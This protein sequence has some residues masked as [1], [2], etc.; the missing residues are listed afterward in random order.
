VVLIEGEPGIGKSALVRA[1]LADCASLGCQVFW[2]TGS[3]LDQ[4]LPLQ[5]LL[6]GL[7]VRE[8]SPDRRRAT[9][10][11]FLRGEISIDRGMDGSAMLG[12]QL[13]ALIAEEC[14]ARPT[15]LVIDDLQWADNVTIR[16]LARLAGSARELPLLL[17]GMIRPV[18]QRDDLL[19]LRRTAS[20]AVRLGL[21]GLAEAE[22]AELIG[23]LAGGVPDGQLLRLAADAAGN[24]LYITELVE[25]LART[26]RIIVTGGAAVLTAGPAPRSLSAAIADRLGFISGPA[27]EVLQS[28]SLLGPEFPVIDLASLLGRDV[29]DLAAIL[30][31]ACVAGVLAESGRQ[32][33]F[34]HPLI[35]AALYEDLPAPVRTA[36][37]R[38]AGRALAAAGAPPHRVARQLLWAAGEPDGPPEPMDEWILTWLAG[39]AE[40][41]VTQAPQVAA[42]LLAQAV[43]SMPTTA[44]LRG[45]LSGQL[46][47]ALYRTGNKDEAEAVASRELRRAVDPDLLVSLHW[48]LAQCR[49][50]AGLHAE[51]LAAL[52]HALE[53]PGLT[54]RHRGRLLVLA[55]RTYLS[56]GE[57][58][59]AGQVATTALAVAEEACDT[60]AMGWAL[61]TMALVAGI[62][63][64][65]VD[66][67][68]LFDQAMTL[69]QGDVS[70]T[71]L[72]LL[73]QINKAV[74]LASQDRY[75]E[76]LTLARHAR[77]LA[78]E[79]GAIV[80]LTQA[81][82]LLGQLLFEVGRW[83]DAL[84]EQAAMPQRIEG[85]LA[86][87]T[88][89]GIA[90]LISFH[91]GDATAARGFLAAADSHAALTGRML[92]PALM[93]ARSLDLERAG[94]LPAALST[95]TH[96]IDGSTEELSLVQDIIPD[97]VR[98]AMRVGDLDTAQA[99]TMRAVDFAADLETPS[100]QGNSLYCRGMLGQDAPL[101]L[102]AA[103]R[104]ER[105]SRPLL[106]AMALESA[107]AAHGEVGDG[108][109]ARAALA[110]A[111]RVYTL[112]GALADAA[113]TKP[114]VKT[115]GAPA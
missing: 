40:L 24:P 109:G 101:L 67:L 62:Q 38:E 11:R 60:W 20:D 7:R 15:I 73:L 105:A 21:A 106:R 6:D 22:A 55:A 34:R 91:R 66:Q 100:A 23:C 41:L 14:T 71:D 1:A 31:E 39:A 78:R 75:E 96:W 69:T 77:E 17:V 95:L 54:A 32:L 70:L 8:P 3:E 88:E 92:V 46:A 114:A 94:A 74:S 30:H 112:L 16:L 63:G 28:A 102:A 49:L 36:W 26:S 86:A 87:C 35:H 93:L 79:A 13:L 84:A 48:T 72:R 82:G 42:R 108:E 52:D 104:Y 76:A 68:R 99:I 110:S 47:D 27:R 111:T 103:G 83:D 89:L 80:R 85:H 50:G 107:A 57:L 19:A 81:H 97:A 5:P 113:R 98:L 115:A 44:P 37:H 33:R 61:H 2:G 58:G 25:V 64:R 29:A 59:K 10:A 12:E 65:L 51:S 45:R 9:I 90:A 56:R 53:A 18:P 43:A 4:A